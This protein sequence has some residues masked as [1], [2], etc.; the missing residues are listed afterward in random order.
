MDMLV[1]FDKGRFI[2]IRCLCYASI[3]HAL[4]GHR[5]VWLSKSY[6]ELAPRPS[7]HRNLTHKLK[8]TGGI[9]MNL[10]DEC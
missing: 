1:N 4:E 3:V 6:V 9:G 8:L 10:G 5:P 7:P 2:D